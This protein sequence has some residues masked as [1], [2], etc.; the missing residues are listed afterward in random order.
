[1]DWESTEI[2]ASRYHMDAILQDVS[3][4]V[5][6]KCVCDSGITHMKPCATT[7]QR[8]PS[9]VMRPMFSRTKL[10]LPLVCAGL[11]LVA[12]GCAVAEPTAPQPFERLPE[13][14]IITP[15]SSPLLGKNINGPALIRVPDW[16]PDPLGRYYL[17]F[18]HH[19]GDSIRLAYADSIEGPWKIHEPGTLR[20]DQV[21]DMV[22]GHIASPDIMVDEAN[23]QIVMYY[24]GPLNPKGPGMKTAQ[25]FVRQ[26]LPPK[27]KSKP[28]VNRQFTSVA[29]SKDGLHFEPAGGILAPFYARVFTHEGS[30]F[31]IAKGLMED[32]LLMRRPS[33]SPD[34]P[35]EAVKKILPRMRHCAVW[36]DGQRLY[37][38]YSRIGDAPEHIVLSYVD[39]TGDPSKWK[40]SA[41]VSLLK[42]EKPW[43]GAKHPVRPSRPGLAKGPVNEMRDPAL[44]TEG[45]T[46]YLIYSIAGESGLAIAKTSL[47]DFRKLAVASEEGVAD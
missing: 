8:V 47:D 18:A 25:D 42:P 33:G 4:I 44:F 19:A 26:A 21:K 43:E 16:L 45:G 34:T 5:V 3:A 37:V 28:N 36:I 9:P 12:F 10:S 41:P 23:K 17:Y 29:V 15:A 24:H 27:E 7:V 2:D 31:C 1:M 46:M 39:T 35:F 20:L 14:P 22:Q 13:N 40:F 11:M 6:K 30:D 32:G 38:A